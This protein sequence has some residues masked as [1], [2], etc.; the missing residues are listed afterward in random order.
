MNDLAESAPNASAKSLYRG[1]FSTPM[2][3]PVLRPGIGT[4]AETIHGPMSRA[5][6][7]SRSAS[8]LPKR[9]TYYLRNGGHTVMCVPCDGDELDHSLWSISSRVS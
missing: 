6:R 3:F 4:L 8:A 2:S 5:D 1:E 9:L 7:D